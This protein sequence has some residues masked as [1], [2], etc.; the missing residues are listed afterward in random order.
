M[1]YYELF[2]SIT[3]TVINHCIII[4]IVLIVLSKAIQS[5]KTNIEFLHVT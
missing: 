4:I 3:I 1:S 2:I 5:N